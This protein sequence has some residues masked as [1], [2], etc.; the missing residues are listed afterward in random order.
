M[1]RRPYHEEENGQLTL[2]EVRQFLGRTVLISEN[3]VYPQFQGGRDT[4]ID[5]LS[6]LPNDNDIA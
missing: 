3:V 4:F 6:G 5:D 1:E 2:F